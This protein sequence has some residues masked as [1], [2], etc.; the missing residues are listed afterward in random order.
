MGSW[1]LKERKNCLSSSRM[2]PNVL[3]SFFLIIYRLHLTNILASGRQKKYDL[4]KDELTLSFHWTLWE[5]SHRPFYMNLLSL[6]PEGWDKFFKPEFLRFTHSFVTRFR[7]NYELSIPWGSII[8]SS[9]FLFLYFFDLDMILLEEHHHG[10]EKTGGVYKN[11]IIKLNET[12]PK[13]SN[14]F[15]TRL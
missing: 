1:W 11:E 8:L 6:S 5:A 4:R 10:F 7:I 14:D 15:C 13:K 3:R 2:S 9:S 12:F